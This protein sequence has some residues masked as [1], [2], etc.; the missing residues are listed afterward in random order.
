MIAKI[1]V[2]AANFSIDKPY[3]YAVPADMTLQP[4]LRVMVPFGRSNRHTEGVVLSVSEGDENGLKL[5]ASCL[6]DAPVVSGRM[7]QLAAFMRERYFCTFFD[8]LRVMLPA[9]LWFQ[10]KDTYSLTE[11]VSWQEKRIRQ[12]D[13]A[14]I[15]Q[16][17]HD[18]GG[19]CDGK[20]LRESISSEE[21]F[22]K[23]VTYLLKRNGSLPSGIFPE[24]L[25]I[26]QR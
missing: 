4:G 8:C 25:T 3:S 26:R 20:I 2:S 6:D 13:A 10:S 15:L 24:E 11:D 12:T 23:A 18:C 22:E 17:L 5:V 1:A 21:A 9:G 16:Q 19:S 7:L 14:T